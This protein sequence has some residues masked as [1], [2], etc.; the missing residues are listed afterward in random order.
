MW[1]D[2]VLRG[3]LAKILPAM[4]RREIYLY[5]PV[6]CVLSYNNFGDLQNYTFLESLGPTEPEK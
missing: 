5:S 3:I 4:E 1:V 6:P 2:S